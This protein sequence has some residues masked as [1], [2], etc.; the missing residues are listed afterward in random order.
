MSHVVVV[1][2]F[3]R[4]VDPELRV[5]IADPGLSRDLFPNDYHC[6]GDSDN[7]PL[8]WLAPESLLLRH[9]SAASDVVS[10]EWGEW[11]VG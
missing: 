1:V 7:R 3:D 5:K 11:R 8:C 2:V 6:L 10:G 9:F 4:R